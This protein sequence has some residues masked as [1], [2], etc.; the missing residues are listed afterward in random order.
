MK[1][2]GLKEGF[3][4]QFPGLWGSVMLSNQRDMLEAMRN[5]QVLRGSSLFLAGRESGDF[6][7][8]R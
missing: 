1:S 2:D 6:T 4:S 8:P 7:L 5:L 3:G